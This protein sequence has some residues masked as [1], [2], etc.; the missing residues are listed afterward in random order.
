MIISDIINGVGRGEF[1]GWD[2]MGWVWV[3]RGGMSG[4][5]VVGG[6]MIIV[7]FNAEV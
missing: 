5:E 1:T 3:G 2:G 7:S 6:W 4:G